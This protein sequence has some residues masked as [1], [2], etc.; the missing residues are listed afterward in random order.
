MFILNENTHI[1]MT[2]IQWLWGGLRPNPLSDQQVLSFKK[3]SNRSLRDQG[4]ERYKQSVI[5]LQLRIFK[6]FK[7]FNTPTETVPNICFQ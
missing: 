3:L 4:L 1:A 2:A 5:I 6:N 7:D